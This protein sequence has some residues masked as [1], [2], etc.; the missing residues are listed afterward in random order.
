M[1]GLALVLRLLCSHLM[2]WLF[3]FSFVEVVF[4]ATD[5]SWIIVVSFVSLLSFLGSFVLF[6]LDLGLLYPS[7]LLT[8]ANSVNSSSILFASDALLSS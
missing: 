5:A 3:G 2:I 1:I 7:F 8:L 4:V 6:V